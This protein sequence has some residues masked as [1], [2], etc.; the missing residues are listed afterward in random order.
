MTCYLLNLGFFFFF[1]SVIVPH[2]YY[3]YHF[4]VSL[5]TNLVMYWVLN[6]LTVEIWRRF[7]I[8]VAVKFLKNL[9]R[10][11][12]EIHVELS[13]AWKVDKIFQSSLWVTLRALEK[14]SLNLYE[15]KEVPGEH[16]KFTEVFTAVSA[17]DMLICLGQSLKIY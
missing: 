17:Y 8:S 1:L 16:C 9:P 2:V 12:K 14:K 5:N 3:Q 7:L 4:S 10:V 15:N 11:V 6:S 13:R